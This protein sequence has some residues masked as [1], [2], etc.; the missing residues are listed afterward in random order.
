MTAR[1]EELTKGTR[2]RGISPSGPVTVIS[3]VID[4]RSTTGPHLTFLT[5]IERLTWCLLREWTSHA[6]FGSRSSAFSEISM[7]RA[8]ATSQ[9]R[10]KLA[11]RKSVDS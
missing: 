11:E 5:A 3:P 8:A 4:R 7:S 10:A 1:L 9:M 6:A 2:V